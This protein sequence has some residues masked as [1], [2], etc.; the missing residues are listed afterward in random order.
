[1]SLAFLDKGKSFYSFLREIEKKTVETIHKN[2]TDW[3]YLPSQPHIRKI[4]N[5]QISVLEL[6]MNLNDSPLL[7][8]CIPSGC[9]IFKGPKQMNEVNFQMDN[10]LIILFHIEGIQFDTKSFGYYLSI[11]PL[12]IKIMT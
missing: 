7:N 9:H 11:K 10:S 6:P 8:V 12:Q 1:M 3:L 2:S 4:R 5:R